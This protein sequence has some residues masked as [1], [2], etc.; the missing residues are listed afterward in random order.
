[1]C[2]ICSFLEGKYPNN[3]M[4]FVP[5]TTHDYRLAF[6]QATQGLPTDVCRDILWKMVLEVTPSPPPVPTRKLRPIVQRLRLKGRRSLSALF[7]TMP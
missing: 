7:A 3:P 1:M 6:V 4:D 2:V 5:L